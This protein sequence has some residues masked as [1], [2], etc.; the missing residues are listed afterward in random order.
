MYGMARE[1]TTGTRTGKTR[2]AAYLDAIAAVLGD[3]RRAASARAYCT[4]LLL[5]GERKSVEPMA[6][7]IEPGRVQAKHQSLHHVVAKAEWDDAALLAAV[8]AQVLPAIERHGPVAYWIIDDTSFPKQGRHSVGVARQYCGELGKQDNCQVAVSL[9]V[10]NDHASLP[11]AY[12]LYLPETWA[13]DPAR[14]AKA[15]IPEEVGFATKT[16]IVLGQIRQALADGVPEGLVLGGAGYGD[17]TGFRVGVDALGL[18]YV[19]GVRPGTT[20]WP[21]GTGP[22][23]PPAAFPPAALAEPLQPPPVPWSGRGRPPIRLRRGPENQPVALKPLAESLAPR[24]WRKVTWREGTRAGLSSRFAALRVRPAHRDTLRSEPWPEAWLLI[25][26]PAGAHEPSKY[27]LS[28]L[29]PRIALK[30]L[31]HTAKARWRIER[32]YQEL[33]QEI[34]LG[35]YEGRGWRGFHHHASLSIAAYGFLVAERCLFPP[36]AR[37]T[38]E[39]IGAPALP[40][41]FQPRG[42]AHPA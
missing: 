9:Y 19:L 27:W 41:G 34:G 6:A 21:P 35:H 23:P 1:R 37:F 22:R 5:P 30:R 38:R 33:K 8:R 24:A 7:R 28:N 3:V 36:Q 39:R 11:I 15:G 29:P 42:A 16:A 40:Q 18:R 13:E 2:F 14:R 12:R 25:E 10:A 32:D 26:W 17:E 31:V 4:G 20:V